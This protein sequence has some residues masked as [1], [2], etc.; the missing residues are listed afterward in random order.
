MNTIYGSDCDYG[1]ETTS[2]DTS[3]IDLSSLDLTDYAK[4]SYVNAQD[5]LKVNKSG[6]RMTGN[7][8]MGNNYILK[9]ANPARA[10]DAA[11]KQYVDRAANNVAISQV[12][13][14]GD[15]MTGDLRMNANLVK[16]LPISYP[17]TN[18]SGSEA[19]SWSQARRLVS[20][21]TRGLATTSYV[22]NKITKPI[23][24]VWAEEKGSLSV[25]CMEFW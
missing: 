9:V 7:L 21:S 10:T 15:S 3:N 5:N 23:I 19:V 22:N 14:R 18:Y 24:T 12:S 25:A 16:G 17:P 4:K 11:S 8:D 13:K 20:G 6:D 1:D 2:I